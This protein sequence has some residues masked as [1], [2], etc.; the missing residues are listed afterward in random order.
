MACPSEFWL[1]V[2]ALGASAA[3]GVVTALAASASA[4]ETWRTVV[5]CVV[6]SGA[7]TDQ[8]VAGNSGGYRGPGRDGHFPATGLL[9]SWPED[10]PKLLWRNDELGWG[11]S[12][13]CVVNGMVYVSGQD[14]LTRMGYLFAFTLD[15]ALKWKKPYGTEFGAGRCSGPRGTPTVS[16]GLIIVPNADDGL[17]NIY[18]FDERTGTRLWHA[19][20]S[21]TYNTDKQGWGYNE[22]PLVIGDRVFVTLLARNRTTPPVVALDKKT[23]QVVWEAAPSDYDNG[24]SATDCSI[25][26][27]EHNGRRLLVAALW[28]AILCLEADTGKLVWRIPAPKAPPN[29]MTPVYHDGLLL[30]ASPV[31]KG[32]HMLLKLSKDGSSYTELWEY[33][34]DGLSQ[35]VFMGDKVFAVRG[36]DLVCIDIASGELLQKQDGYDAGS[37]VAA[38]GLVYWLEGGGRG[39]GASNEYAPGYGVDARLSLVRPTGDGFEVV[40]SFKPERSLRDSW[41]HPTVAEGRLFHRHQPVIAVYDIRAHKPAYGFRRDGTG[42]YPHAIP[43]AR[44][45]QPNVRWSAKLPG[46]GTGPA[47]VVQGKAFVTSGAATLSCHDAATGEQVW[48]HTDPGDTGRK[49]ACLAP[50]VDLQ[51][52]VVCA[53]FGNGAVACL[54]WDGELRWSAQVRAGG[55]NATEPMPSPLVVGDVLVIQSADLHG[56]DLETGTA[57]WKDEL[58]RPSGSGSP[59]AGRLGETDIIVTGARI[60]VRAEDGKVVANDLPA[61]ARAS[62]V[63]SGE[64]VFFAGKPINGETVL[65]AA[66]DLRFAAMRGPR[67]RQA[68]RRDLE[69]RGER[70]ASPLVHGRLLYLLSSGGGLCVLDADT[71]QEVY[72]KRLDRDA[73]GAGDAAPQLCAVNGNIHAMF[74]AEP[75]VTAIF[76]PGREFRRVWEYATAGKGAAASF[77]VTNLYVRSGD[78]LYHVGGD[79]PAEPSRPEEAYVV[80]AAPL[81]GPPPD[82]VPVVKFADNAIVADWLCAGPFKPSTLAVDFLEPL[83][84]AAAARPGPGT[85]VTFVPAPQPPEGDPACELPRGEKAT[86]NF[87]PFDSE[88][89]RWQGKHKWA[90]GFNTLDLTKL[91]GGVQSGR[92]SWQYAPNRAETWYFYTILD[93]DRQR[94][95]QFRFLTPGGDKW[96]KAD[97]VSAR[98]WVAGNPVDMGTWLDGRLQYLKNQCFTLEPG[99]YP[100]TMQV[101]VGKTLR[102][103]DRIWAAPRFIEYDHEAV[104]AGKQKEYE[105][106][107]AVWRDYRVSLKKLLTL[108]AP[109]GD[110]Q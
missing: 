37:L 51:R 67:L 98:A 43:L 88:K 15:G 14:P 24:Y 19:D 32:K 87:E 17:R 91:T 106:R 45:W 57:R 56:L 100:V 55:G 30:V 52:E 58:R 85:E 59:V 1:L 9:K 68:W 22:S 13:P 33:S 97:I 105:A 109:N 73:E 74:G 66:Y 20:L 35:A 29:G 81:R 60:A 12:S 64:R 93:N 11:Y 40:S 6:L 78:R 2:A 103:W 62:P 39:M 5:A 50:V 79:L 102:S 71:G 49:P 28:R 82:G 83:G 42:H 94:S 89:L 38:E 110:R 34:L 69:S 104:H 61:M 18:C 53:V 8:A 7:L 77:A 90:Q 75:S 27:F 3:V 76:R 16:D 108:G 84:G 95:V 23:G 26:G 47:V 101:A 107:L 92:Q 4:W 86:R 25:Q 72:R 36:R 44:W 46:K 65:A 99:L 41:I 21:S 54:S 31:G 70:F 96:M 10:G 63:V 80:A 48:S